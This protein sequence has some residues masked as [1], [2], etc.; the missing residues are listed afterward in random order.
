MGQKAI[1]VE[2]SE[3]AKVGNGEIDMETKFPKVTWFYRIYVGPCYVKQYADMLLAAGYSANTG[4]EHVYGLAEDL[5]DGWGSI[6]LEARF[7]ELLGWDSRL[8]PVREIEFQKETE[9]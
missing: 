9:R 4:T 6:G 3:N 2:R 5:G 7:R 8:S 1:A